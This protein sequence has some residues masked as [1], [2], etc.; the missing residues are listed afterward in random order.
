MIKKFFEKS[1][2]WF[3]PRL[4]KQLFDVMKQVSGECNFGLDTRMYEYNPDVPYGREKLYKPAVDAFFFKVL[5]RVWRASETA[6]FWVYVDAENGVRNFVCS[7]T[8][9]GNYVR[10]LAKVLKNE[11][12]LELKVQ[13]NWSKLWQNSQMQGKKVFDNLYA[14]YKLETSSLYADNCA[15]YTGSFRYKMQKMICCQLGI[16]HQKVPLALS[17]VASVVSFYV[18]QSL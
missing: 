6:E 11:K 3:R 4:E 10:C 14:V 5:K 7:D 8:T 2:F 1:Y 9:V 16:K 18:A 13:E 17:D 15:G 12:G